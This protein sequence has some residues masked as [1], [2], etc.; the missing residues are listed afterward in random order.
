[1]L[2]V[3]ASAIPFALVAMASIG[4]GILIIAWF[5]K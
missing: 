1:M 3:L 5:S 4:A 2:E